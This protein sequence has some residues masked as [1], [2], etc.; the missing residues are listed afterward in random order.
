[1][2]RICVPSDFSTCAGYA[3]DL[4]VLIAEKNKAE[5]HVLH[6]FNVNEG[7]I[8]SDFSTPF[9]G[10]PGTM[11]A[12]QINSYVEEWLRSTKEQL[13]TI[14][15]EV[16]GRG[17]KVE[18]HMVESGHFQ[19]ISEK[20]DELNGDLVVMGSHGSK[21]L[22][23]RFIGSNTQRFIRHSEVPVLV[24]KQPPNGGKLYNVAFCSN[25][26]HEGEKEVYHRFKHLF[27]KFPIHTHFLL[28]NT[29][30]QFISTPVAQKRID[31]FLM[32]TWPSNYDVHI[33]NDHSV[34]EGIMNFC[35][36]KNIDML[37]LGTHGYTGIKR[38][39]RHSVTEGIVNHADIP[40]LTFCLE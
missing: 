33:Y 18:T 26:L 10:V 27:G 38:I 25:F 16:S 12:E 22:E 9:Q 11:S 3:L 28:V 13:A 24:T 8:S 36:E 37:V 4:A 30:S 5:I 14:K 32:D 17:I 35:E 19:G 2:K 7:I 39:L 34:D 1:M 21:G 31:D 20:I 40:V 29:P 23:E 15:K 6:S